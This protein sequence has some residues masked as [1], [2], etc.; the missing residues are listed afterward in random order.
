MKIAT[1]SYKG[2]STACHAG[3][4]GLRPIK[5]KDGSVLT[6]AQAV[7]SHY[8]LEGFGQNSALFSAAVLASAS[9]E[10][11]ILAPGDI[12]G[13]LPPMLHPDKIIGVWANYFGGT[14][15]PESTG[16]TPIFFSK[17]NNALIG[18]RTAIMLPAASSRV[19]W[20]PE[21]AVVIGR[22][23][24]QVR[25]A[26]ALDYVGGYTVANDVTAFDHT[27]KALLGVIGPHMIAKTFDTFCPLGPHIVTPDEVGDP[28]AL[29]MK[30]WVDGKLIVDGSTS[31]M[32]HRVDELVS[33]LSGRMTLEPGDMILTGTPPIKGEVGIEE[34]TLKV[35]Q[36][37]KIEIERIGTLV[38]FVDA[39]GPRDVVTKTLN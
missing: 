31:G 13:Y 24:A 14:A 25:P 3:P 4:D 33:Y 18:D 21:L 36:E 20:E 9:E 27:L 5:A 19:G 1:V 37:I 8:G 11:E 26:D 35:G 30:L 12:D 15:T 6:D 28:Q 16:D 10:A 34:R 2:R 22:R 29:Q 7:F 23:A 32:K 38:S 39:S 17:F